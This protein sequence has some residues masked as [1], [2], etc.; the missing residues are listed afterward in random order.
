MNPARRSRRHPPHPVSPDQPSGAKRIASASA[1]QNCGA[2]TVAA[3]RSGQTR[4]PDPAGLARAA[5]AYLEAK[6]PGAVLELLAREPH[7][8]CPV[9]LRL[10]ARALLALGHHAPAIGALFEALRLDA[11]DIGTVSLVASALCDDGQAAMALPY[12]EAA[13]CRQPDAAHA[14]TLSC[15][16][17]AL[18]RDEEALRVA[19]QGLQQRPAVPELLLNQAIAL[20]GLGRMPEAIA[21]GR[22]ALAAAPD[23]AFTQY[24]L[25][26]TLLADGQMTAEAWALHEGRLHL[27]GASSIPGHRLCWNGGAVAGKTVLLHAEQG[28]G[29]TLQFVRYAPSV[30]ALGARVVLAVQPTLVRLL[31]GTPGADAVVPINGTLP[32]FDVY[33]PLLSLPRVFGTTL[34]S[35]PLP[36]PY[37]VAIPERKPGPLRVGVAWAGNPGFIMDRKRSIPAG[38]LAPLGDVPGVVLHSLQVGTAA[39]PP[40]LR[41]G[42]LDGVRDLADTADRIAGLD[43]VVTVDTAVAHLAATMGLP[44]W[45]MSRHRGCWRWLRN[46]EDSPWYPSL[47]VLRQPR[48]EDWDSV[49]ERVRDDLLTAAKARA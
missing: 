40:W 36:L 13:F 46:R 3:C 12:G 35:I 4:R 31:E 7:E 8:P 18:G 37:R 27:K 45:L 11:D 43:L 48:P 15:I 5:A 25:A 1:T 44:V 34:G 22:K 14:T 38:L 47:R 42:L 29:D 9:L 32:P 21:A 6:N 26:A 28:L 19:Q 24:H 2:G 16:L 39:A 20:E 23:N 33:L 30:A 10:L 41:A 17:I 49:I